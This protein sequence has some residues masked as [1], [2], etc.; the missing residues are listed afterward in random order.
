M[1]C[2]FY[3]INYSLKFFNFC[4]HYHLSIRF[5]LRPS[6]KSAF[7]VFGKRREINVLIE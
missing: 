5:C 7:V 2:V 3:V 6:W 1:L 4:E